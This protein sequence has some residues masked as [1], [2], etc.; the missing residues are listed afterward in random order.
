MIVKNYIANTREINK[1]R[2]NNFSFKN[3]R[4]F[5]KAAD[6]LKTTGNNSEDSA[7]PSVGESAEA[8][9]TSETT[10]PPYSETDFLDEV[11][12]S[13]E[14]YTKLKK[15]LLR[16]RNVILQGAP[17]VG[18]TFAAQRLAFSIMGIQDKSRVG[19]IQFHQ[20]YSYEDFVIGY[21]PDEKG[22]SLAEGQFYKFCKTAKADHERPY[23]FIIDEINRGNLSKIFGE[24]L[25]LIEGDKRGEDNA[26]RLLYKGEKFFIP[27]NVYI[28]GMMNTADRSLAMIDYA[29]RRRF[30]FFDMEP[31]FD[32]VGFERL[33][34]NINNPK[35]DTLVAKV[36]EL[37]EEIA[38]DASL[39]AGFRI[40]HSYFCPQK[41]EPVNDTWLASVVEY[42]LIPLLCEYWFDESSNVEKWSKCMRDAIK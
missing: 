8:D 26:L 11:F 13:N 29:L 34:R 42:E 14:S 16:K 10:Y 17:G 23:F 38:K 12:I 18:K 32:S 4:V 31:A 30:A 37:N 2:D 36:K 1:F 24:L 20:S 7:K 41:S 40:G 5:D 6:L 39:G 25:M 9:D 19:V 28:I 3:H 27:D 15:L 21:R 22:F 35:F 33:Q